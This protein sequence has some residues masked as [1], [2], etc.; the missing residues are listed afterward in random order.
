MAKG[1]DVL[2]FDV[3]GVVLDY[4]AGYYQFLAQKYPTDRSQLKRAMES[5][6]NQWDFLESPA[7]ANLPPL[8]DPAMFNRLTQ[9]ATVFFVTN[10]PTSLQ[11]RR[12]EN[13]RKLGFAF[14]QVFMGG[15]E[16][17]GESNY[18]TKSEVLQQQLASQSPF[19]FVDDHPENCQEI[20]DRFPLSTVLLLEGY[21]VIPSPPL[22][23]SRV[24]DWADLQ[25]RIQHFRDTYGQ[26]PKKP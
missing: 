2:V 17:Y 8:V 23:Y 7:I 6:N 25:V 18:P 20:F 14:D 19:C 13:L 15:L 4:Q 9:D 26:A 21:Y 12:E 24:K 22:P 11:L 10:L 16:S 5:W 1:K 3:D